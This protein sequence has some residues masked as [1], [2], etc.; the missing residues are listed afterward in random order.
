[1][2]WVDRIFDWIM[3]PIYFEVSPFMILGIAFCVVVLVMFIKRVLW[4]EAV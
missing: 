1:M 2:G 3:T 4:M